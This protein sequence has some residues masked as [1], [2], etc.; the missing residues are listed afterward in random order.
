MRNMKDPRL[1]KLADL[2][3]HYSLKVQPKENVVVIC[4]EVAIPWLKEVVQAAVQ[5][6]G[7]VETLINC[8][9]INEIRLKYSNDEQLAQQNKLMKEAVAFADVMIT[10]WGGRNTKIN[11]GIDSQKI[12]QDRRSQKKWRDL[13]TQKMGD[14]ELRWCGTQFPTHSDAQEASMSLEDYEKFVYGAGLLHMENPFAEWQKISE[15][16]QRWVDYL[17]Q[18]SELHFITDETD[19]KVGVEGRKWINCDGKV[20][21]PD[22]EIFTSPVEESINGKISFSFPGIYAGKEI[23][24]IRLNI[25]DGV[26]ESATADKGEDL[27]KALI[28]TDEGSCRF[29]EVAI[30]TN[31]NIKRFTRNM[32]FDEK[33]GGTIHMALGD[34]MIEAG[35]LNRS[36]LHWDLLCD[37]RNGGKIFADGELFY[38]DGKFIDSVLKG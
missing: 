20:N 34:S 6:G 3:I 2:L 28:K 37:M 27:L 16:Q 5:A 1:T 7:N 11:A 24:G 21:F 13:M 10:A 4:D 15:S 32:L 29:G 33:I 9:E 25:K 36:S 38:E 35:G 22:G 19:L 26:V 31:Y 8:Q 14:G 17:D 30:G 18:K 23:E 12:V